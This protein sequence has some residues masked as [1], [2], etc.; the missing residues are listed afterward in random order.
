MFKLVLKAAFLVK[1]IGSI[2]NY[3]LMA[4]I[5]VAKMSIYFLKKI[6]IGRHRIHRLR[7]A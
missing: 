5:S 1:A 6:A 3:S 7:Q 4:V 2:E